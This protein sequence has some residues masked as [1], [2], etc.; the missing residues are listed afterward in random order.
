LGIDTSP[1]NSN[2]QLY[3]TPSSALFHKSVVSV[4]AY[5][6]AERCLNTQAFSLSFLNHLAYF[7]S[8]VLVKEERKQTNVKT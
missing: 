8:Q 2:T 4:L 5:G 3:F 1:Y 6:M 7:P